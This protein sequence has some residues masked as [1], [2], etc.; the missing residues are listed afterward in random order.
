MPA[1]SRRNLTY[2]ARTL[3]IA[4]SDVEHLDDRAYADVVMYRNALAAAGFAKRMVAL[5]EM[6]EDFGCLAD[7]EKLMRDDAKMMPAIETLIEKFEELGLT[8]ERV[9]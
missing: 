6:S 5:I 1:P 3:G 4:T 9:A 8:P 2:R 7:P